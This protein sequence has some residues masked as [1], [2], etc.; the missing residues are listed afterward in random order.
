M[1]G[2]GGSLGG[3]RGVQGMCQG[4]HNGKESED[5]CVRGCIMESW[6]FGRNVGL[7]L[8]GCCNCFHTPLLV[9]SA[10]NI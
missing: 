10:D 7:I 1:G 8:V 5:F 6:K 3:A 4:L 9:R 2:P